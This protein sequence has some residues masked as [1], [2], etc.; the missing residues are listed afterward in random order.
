MRWGLV[1]WWSKEAKGGGKSIQ[2]RSETVIRAPAFREAW[3]SGRC[4][5]VVDGFYEW[6]GERGRRSAPR[7]PHH[8]RLAGG[9][10]FAIAA[11]WDSWRSPEGMPLET[12]AVITAPARGGIAA[13][14]DRMPLVLNEEDRERWMSA[15]D[16]ARSVLSDV[17]HQQARADEL[18]IVPIANWVNDVQNDDA[19]C[20]DPPQPPPLPAQTTLR[21]E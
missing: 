4:L 11:V 8:I 3:K 14:H 7:K 10:P 2:A 18:V 19:R 1:P 5:F 21:F 6:S 15:D 13:L 9:G 17:A 16:D 20:L 12:C